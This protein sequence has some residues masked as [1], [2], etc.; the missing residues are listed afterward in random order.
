M[1]ANPWLNRDVLSKRRKERLNWPLAS[2]HMDYAVDNVSDLRN[3]ES[4][5]VVV[6]TAGIENTATN[7]TIK[8]RLPTKGINKGIKTF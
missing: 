1:Q 3:A 4:E 2:I 5:H 6:L 7:I 8:N